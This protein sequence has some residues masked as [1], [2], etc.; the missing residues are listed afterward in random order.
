MFELRPYQIDIANQALR[1]LRQSGLVY[2]AM[3]PRTGKTLTALKTAELY[4]AKR[5]L[6]LT[7]LKAIA[8]IQSDFEKLD[9]SF[10]MVVWNYESIHKLNWIFDLV[11][12]D[13]AHCLS[14]FPKPSKRAKQLKE[15]VW[16]LPVIYLSATPSAE[17]YSQLYHPFWISARSPFARYTNFYKFAKDFVNVKKKRINGWE[18]NDYSNAKEKEIMMMVKP[19][20][21]S[22]SQQEAGFKSFVDEEILYVPIDER[23]YKLMNILK[24]DKVYTLKSG[25]TIV[26]DTPVRLQSLMHQI[27]SGTVI[28][29]NG[30]DRKYHILDKSKAYFIKSKFAGHKLCIFYKFISEGTVLK[31]V[32]PNWTDSPEE[33]NAREDATFIG[34]FASSSLGT[35][36]STADALIAY[37]IDFSATTYFQFRER[38][39]TLIREKNSKLYWIFSER[40][41]EKH[42]HASVSNK[43]DFTLKYFK[44]AVKE[45][46]QLS[47]V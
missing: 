43:L 20:M 6:F 3:Q 40:G 38:M 44:K 37:N 24:K 29:D 23:L 10:T 36:V 39:Q 13:E 7:K 22:F 45:I 4:G 21:I 14:A 27:S 16:N 26:A 41:I 30:T 32:F 46:G 42:V 15:Q 8:S 18:I 31:E 5:V 34:Q 12:C 35:N 47:L 2:L 25:D 17:S 33:F 28:T 1:I 19:L 9:P 11:I